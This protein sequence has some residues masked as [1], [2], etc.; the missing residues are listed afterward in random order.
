MVEHFFGSIGKKGGIQSH[1][2]IGAGIFV[3]SYKGLYL[4]GNPMPFQQKQRRLFAAV[5]R[6][7]LIIFIAVQHFHQFFTGPAGMVVAVRAS[8]RA[9]YLDGFRFWIVQR[10]KSHDRLNL[11]RAGTYI[12]KP[13]CTRILFIGPGK[14]FLHNSQFFIL[15][16]LCNAALDIS[17]GRIW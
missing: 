11:R 10:Q 15:L 1:Q 13:F 16:R 9:V 8:L 12:E 4:H 14:V 6:P 3:V 7:F 2:F 5:R 17:N